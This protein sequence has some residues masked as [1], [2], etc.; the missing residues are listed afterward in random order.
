MGMDIVFAG[1]AALFW[2]AMVLLV[3][4]LQKLHRPQGSR[5]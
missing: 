5:S 4:G 3:R 1:A 2:G